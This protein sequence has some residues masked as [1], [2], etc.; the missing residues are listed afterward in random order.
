MDTI[1]IKCEHSATKALV[2]GHSAYVRNCHAHGIDALEF[3][4]W[5]LTLALQASVDEQLQ[6]RK[7]G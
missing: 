6:Q 2:A 3:T 7:V 1:I 4:S 5:V